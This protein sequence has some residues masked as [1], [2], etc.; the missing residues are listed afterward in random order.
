MGDGGVGLF[1]VVVFSTI[2]P[3]RMDR[4][5]VVSIDAPRV[6]VPMRSCVNVVAVVAGM[7]VAVAGCAGNPFKKAPPGPISLEP[8]PGIAAPAHT[9]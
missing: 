6:C 5:A 2:R 4:A 7:L 1:G 8:P 3:A 9:L